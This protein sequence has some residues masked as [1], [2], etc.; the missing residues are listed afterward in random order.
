MKRWEK[1]NAVQKMQDYIR[2]HINEEINIEDIAKTAGY[3]KRHTVRIFRE[4]LGRTP[5]DYVRAIRLT[6]SAKDLL[7]SQR[8]ILDIALNTQFDT[9]E[10]F[11]GILRRIWN[12]T[13]KIQTGKTSCKIFRAISRQALLFLSL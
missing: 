10:G 8:N 4:L 2:D 7:Q 9:H 3:S 11:Y 13:T 12:N 5:L 1:V 6:N